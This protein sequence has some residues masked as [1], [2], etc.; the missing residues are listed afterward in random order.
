[1]IREK[2]GKLLEASESIIVQTVNCK[3]RM[4][5]GLARQIRER[6]FSERVVAEY[7][8]LCKKHGSELLGRCDLIMVNETKWVANLFTEVIKCA[9]DYTAL[10]VALENLKQKAGCR[11]I[12]L[13]GY[14]SCGLAGG[15]WEKV[16]SMIWKIF[17]DYNGD[18]TIY[19]IDDSV[20]R[21]RKEISNIPVIQ[22]GDEKF[23]EKE[24]HNFP[25]HT[26]LGEIM[27][28]FCETFEV[29]KTT[30][31]P[32][33]ENEYEKFLSRIRETYD[34][35]SES[36][37]ENFNTNRICPSCRRN[38]PVLTVCKELVDTLDPETFQAQKHW[39]EEVVALTLSC[40]KEA[41]VPKSI[42]KILDVVKELAALYGCDLEG[43][44]EEEPERQ[45]ETVTEWCSHC[46]TEVTLQWAIAESGY[47]A[48]C[49]HCGNRLMLCSYCPKQEQC[50]Y[51]KE[52]DTC[53]YN[54]K[55]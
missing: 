16:Y 6:Y 23:T 42:L 48:F 20:N 49:P 2:K 43:K 44:P 46:E 26:S 41:K 55:H 12:A 52:T 5:A 29:K 9:M 35:V 45:T 53:Y 15:D 50:D 33:N 31:E 47:R 7:K 38:T 25:R 22:S 8:N 18:V 32:K 54:H 40:D 14:L 13:P 51:D 28:W 19:Y 10:E 3:G 37:L 36:E 27:R 4:G 11:S 17:G 34:T 1:M 39:L 21:L 24:W 30:E